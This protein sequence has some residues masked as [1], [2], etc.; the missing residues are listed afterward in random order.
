MRPANACE[1]GRHFLHP[2]ET[3]EE[4]E[5]LAAAFTAWF[6]RAL[7]DG[8]SQAHAAAEHDLVHGHGLGEIRGV[9]GL[10]A[11]SEPT[12]LDRALE[13]LGPELQ[14]CPLYQPWCPSTGWP[15]SPREA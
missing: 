5:Q 11:R 10:A 1:S 6:E 14:H 15:R 4:W 9:I 3:C 2:S 7:A 8:L 12:P 13:I